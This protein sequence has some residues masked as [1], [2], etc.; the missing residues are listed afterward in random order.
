MARSA[1]KSR[2]DLP[3]PGSPLTRTSEAGN[4]STAEH[5]IELRDPGR[6]PRRVGRGDVREAD[7]RLGRQVSR[8]ARRPGDLLDERPPAP[9]FGTATQ[10]LPGR[11]AA[12]RAGMLDG[13]LRHPPIVRRGPDAEGSRFVTKVRRGRTDRPLPDHD[14]LELS[15]PSRR[16]CRPATNRRPGRSPSRA[17]RPR[18]A[19]S[20][21]P[22][23]R[24]SCRLESSP[25][26]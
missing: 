12:L 26:A 8:R 13:R 6:K 18:S 15:R 10:P 5:P 16:P 4:D 21:S 19:R 25:P 17:L 1:I 9:A 3:I 22:R 7:E 23:R 20:R 11:V 24:P 2:V 14:Y